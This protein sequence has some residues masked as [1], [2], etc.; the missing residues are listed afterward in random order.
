M[1]IQIGARFLKSQLKTAGK[2]VQVT[3]Q[4][5]FDFN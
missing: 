4:T 3:A 2:Q 1:Y 5:Y